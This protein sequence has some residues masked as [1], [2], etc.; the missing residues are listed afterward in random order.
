MPLDRAN[1]Y[2]GPAYATW[3]SA[4]FQMH[5]DW[6]VNDNPE[7]FSFKSNLQG[8]LDYG[9][10]SVMAEV[11][12]KPIATTTGLSTFLGK[13]LTPFALARGGLLFGGTD[14][15]LVIQTAAG[16]S[17]TFS[18]AAITGATFNFAPGKPLIERVRML[19]LIK[20]STAPSDAAAFVA[21]A[22]SAYTEPAMTPLDAVWDTYTFAWGSTFT[23]IE[24]D[25]NG[26]TFS[27]ELALTPRKTAKRGQYNAS[28]DDIT[29]TVTFTPEGVSE[30]DWY[31][32]LHKLDGT[33]FAIGKLRGNWGESF[34]ATGSAAGQPKLT[35]PRL[36]VS[37]GGVQ[38]NSKGRVSQV[39]MRASRKD[40]T[41]TLGALFTMDVVPE[42]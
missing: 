5:E 34:T 17:I 32:S 42:S 24:T 20:N 1:M 23:D 9:I 18:A 10:L 11:E 13:V 39:T 25:E 37:K 36:F 15:P 8:T 21:V 2:G 38:F 6:T 41:G 22:D 31:N 16:K 33:G 14:R 26:V 27:P 19:C 40:S 4:T 28:V 3:H 7:E 12:F 30:A 35:I 29:A